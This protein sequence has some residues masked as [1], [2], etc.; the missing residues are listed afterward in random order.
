VIARR[1]AGAALG[2]VLL[3]AA[4]AGCGGSGLDTGVSKDAQAQL[5][6]QVAAIRQSAEAGDMAHANTYLADLTAS[7]HTLQSQGKLDDAAGA[8]ILAAAEVVRGQLVAAAPTT[9]APTTTTA[10]PPAPSGD[11]KKKGKGD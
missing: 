1:S 4:G 6:L 7:V 8:R 9:T 2:F 5:D 3:L 10:P 11:H